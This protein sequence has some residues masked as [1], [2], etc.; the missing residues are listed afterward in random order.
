MT[1]RDMGEGEVRE[2]VRCVPAVI[3]NHRDESVLMKNKEEVLEL[4]TRFPVYPD[5]EMFH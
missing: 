1:T 2:L 4:A 3:K 5:F